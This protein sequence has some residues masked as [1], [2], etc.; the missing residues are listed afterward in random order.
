MGSAKLWGQSQ[1]PESGGLAAGLPESR[2]HDQLLNAAIWSLNFS[3]PST[4]PVLVQWRI[5]AMVSMSKA[6][7]TCM[8]QAFFRSVGSGASDKYNSWGCQNLTGAP[9]TRQERNRLGKCP[10]PQHNIEP[11]LPG[12]HNW[13]ISKTPRNLS[14]DSGT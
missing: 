1:V 9:W 5:L 12:C 6:S 8:R 14:A 11:I 2:A 13:K 10:P 3:V 4:N 7:T